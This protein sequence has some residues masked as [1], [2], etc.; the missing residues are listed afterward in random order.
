MIK[1]LKLWKFL[2]FISYSFSQLINFI[3]LKD[4]GKEADKLS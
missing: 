4:K 3:Q 2:S 1:F